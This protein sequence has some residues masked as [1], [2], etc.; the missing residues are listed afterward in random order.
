[1]PRVQ[2]ED[3]P[4]AKPNPG[5]VYVTR[6]GWV[7]Y[8]HPDIETVR[9][10]EIRELPMYSAHMMLAASDCVTFRT[11]NSSS[12][13]G[14]SRH[15]VQLIQSASSIEA[16]TISQSSTF[17][18]RRRHH[19]SLEDLLRRLRRKTSNGLQRSLEPARSGTWTF[20]AA[21][22]LSRFSI[23]TTCQ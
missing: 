22:R 12:I 14:L 2:F 5:R 9:E 21:E 7:H 8:G 11:T 6:L 20:L 15:I 3:K 10:K 4:W 17:L 1:M 18:K 13:S 23:P 16:T 19:N